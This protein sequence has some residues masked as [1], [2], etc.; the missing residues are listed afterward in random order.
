[1]QHW[2]NLILIWRWNTCLAIF[3]FVWVC[4]CEWSCQPRLLEGRTLGCQCRTPPFGPGW[5]SERGCRLSP[6]SLLACPCRT[7]AGADWTW[8]A[9]AWW[10]YSIPW[11]CQWILTKHFL[12]SH[13]LAQ[14]RARDMEDPRYYLYTTRH[15]ADAGPGLWAGLSLQPGMERYFRVGELC[16][17]LHPLFQLLMKL[18]F[19][20]S[21]LHCLIHGHPGIH[22]RVDDIPGTH[23]VLQQI[24]GHL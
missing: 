19:F 23:L 24:Y 2:T 6:V 11:H 10:G 3:R 4:V 15:P 12:S 21:V 18:W 5:P 22:G 16:N 14:V 17:L 13:Y 7:T 20:Q 9:P 8:P 1:M